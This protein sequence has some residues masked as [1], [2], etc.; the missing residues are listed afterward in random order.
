MD[1]RAESKRI[2][3]N[4]VK[5]KQELYEKREIIRKE[6]EENLQDLKEASSKGDRSENAAFTSATEKAQD[7]EIQYANVEE[8]INQIEKVKKEEKY[9]NIGMV[10]L[11][12]TVLLEVPE[13]NKQLVLK[14]YPKGVSNVDKGI[15]AM[16]TAVGKAI[17]HKKINDSFYVTTKMTGSQL[18]YILKDFY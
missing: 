9:K 12:T 8:Q 6:M 4:L 3:E 10:V 15:L 7:L 5:H 16:D 1:L 17:W 14:L 13:K 2:S 11:Y 18:K